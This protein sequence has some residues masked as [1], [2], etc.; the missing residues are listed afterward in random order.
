MV[1]S[2]YSRELLWLEPINLV[3]RLQERRLNLH[4]ST[5]SLK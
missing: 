4:L 5:T 2:V 3:I 1:H